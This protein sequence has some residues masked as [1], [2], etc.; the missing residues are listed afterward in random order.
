MDLLLARPTNAGKNHLITN[1]K[2]RIS[3]NTTFTTKKL[4]YAPEDFFLLKFA[5]FLSF[6]RVLLSTA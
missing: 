6:E 4:K 1:L 5:F 2:P 3:A